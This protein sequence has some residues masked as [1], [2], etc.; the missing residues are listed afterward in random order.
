MAKNKNKQPKAEAKV[1]IEAPAIETVAI[2]A[3]EEVKADISPVKER[4]PESIEG[5]SHNPAL[6]VWPT[7]IWGLTKDLK[8]EFL[9]AASRIGGQADK[10]A[11]LDATLAIAHAYLEAKYTK[12]A[13]LLNARIEKLAADEAAATEQPTLF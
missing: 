6:I 9:R 12:D 5:I 11:L 1:V 4:R 10:K 7:D 2:E 8:K 3:T 13:S